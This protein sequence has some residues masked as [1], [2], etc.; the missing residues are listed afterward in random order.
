[1]FT[2]VLDACTLYPAHLRDLLLQLAA[3]GLY[4]ACWTNHIHEE[5][6]G[7]LLANRPDLTREQLERT[8]LMMDQYAADSL[9]TGYDKLIESIVLP[10]SGDRHVVAAAVRAGADGIVTY[11][12][13]DFPKES[14]QEFGIEAIHPDDFLLAQFHLNTGVFIRAV[15]KM[16]Q[17]LKNPPK[18]ARELLEI[19]GK[20]T[21]PETI[22]ALIEFEDVI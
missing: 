1:M 21:L 6:I 13:K 19:L 22:R 11:N 15:Q 7:N 20:Q 17:R 8:R 3:D 18:T 12:L 16:R 10:D 14:L 9:I 4:R 5:W 2:V